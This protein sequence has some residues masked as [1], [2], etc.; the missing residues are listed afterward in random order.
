MY[1]GRPK[2]PMTLRR[3]L[4]AFA[5]TFALPLHGP[6]RAQTAAQQTPAEPAADALALRLPP[7]WRQPV[8]TV[9]TISETQRDDLLK[10]ADDAL[11][12]SLARMLL[13]TAKADDFLKAQLTIDRS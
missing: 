9:L 13:R 8:A 5:V 3:A 12:Q 6:I 4:L 11:R 2:E 10:L 7:D 1:N